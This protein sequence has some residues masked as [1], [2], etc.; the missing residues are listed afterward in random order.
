MHTFHINFIACPW[1][2]HIQLVTFFI[3]C[4]VWFFIISFLALGHFIA[5]SLHFSLPARCDLFIHF[6]PCPGPFHTHS[7]VFFIACQVQFFIHFIPCP[8]A[9][10]T[11]LIACQVQFIYSFNS[12]LWA[13]L[14]PPC[15]IFHCLPGVIFY[16]F[17]PCPGPFHT[18]LIA[19]QVRFIY[20]FHSL[21]WAISYPPHCIFHCLPG[22]SF[23]LFQSLLWAISF[24]AWGHFIP[25]L[26]DF[27]LPARC[28]FLSIS[29]LAL[30]HFICTQD[31]NDDTC[32]GPSNGL[33]GWWSHDQ[34]SK[35]VIIK[36]L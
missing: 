13:I 12:L 8:G 34:S 30:G 17:I 14:Y 29:F 31:N 22:V 10:H 26:L 3:T 1:V 6:I 25:T 5:T 35:M 33:L 19:C 36:K 18:L 21:P 4:Q 2:F 32:Q 9:F 23:Y 28:D 27:S 24:L 15:C 16:H 7:V 11:L 20:S